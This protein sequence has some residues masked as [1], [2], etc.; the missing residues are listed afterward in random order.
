ME[1]LG[2]YKRGRK[3]AGYIFISSEASRILYI[4]RTKRKQ[5]K[6]RPEEPDIHGAQQRRASH[7]LLA[8]DGLFIG[9][10]K[11]KKKS[12]SGTSEFNTGC[13]M[14][15]GAIE[16]EA[17]AHTEGE[18]IRNLRNPIEQRAKPKPVKPTRRRAVVSTTAL[19]TIRGVRIDPVTVGIGP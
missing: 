9:L 17:L 6:K 4:R 3:E 18:S 13:D 5:S 2:G 19:N 16:I 7:S 15:V 1:A 12:P 11:K 10:A 14:D 8:N